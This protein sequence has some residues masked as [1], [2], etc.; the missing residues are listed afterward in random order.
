[1]RKIL[2]F[3]MMA[4]FSVSMF[5]AEPVTVKSTFTKATKPENNKVTDLAE[6]VTWDIATTV[7]AGEP[8][9]AV[10]SSNKVECLK[11]GNSKSIYFSKVEF[12]TDY[13]KDYNVTSVKFGVVNNGNKTGTFTAKQGETTIG[14]E[15]KEFGNSAWEELTATGAKGEGGTLTVTYEVEQAFY[16]SYIEVT[17]EAAGG[18]DPAPT[19]RTLYCKVAQSW[20]KA[21]GAA[22][23]IYAFK[24]EEKNATWPGVRMTLAENET[25][26]WTATID[27]K[28][29]KVIFVRVNASGDIAD[30]GAKTTDLTLADAGE[31]DLYTVTSSEPVWSNQGGVVTGTWSKY[32][33]SESPAQPKYFLKNNWDGADTWTWKEMTYYE[34]EYGAYYYLTQVVFGGTGVNFNTTDSEAGSKWIEAKDIETYD[35]SLEPATL[36]ALDTVVIYFTPEAVNQYTGANGLSAT[37]LGKYVDPTPQP[38]LADGFYLIGKIG[39]VAGWAITDLKA[40]Q[41][42]APNL[43]NPVEFMI[44]VTL[45]EGDELKVVNV[46]NNEITA[47]FPGDDNFIVTAAYAGEKTVYFRPDQQGGEGWHRGCIYIA[48]NPATGISNNAVEGKAVKMIMDGQLLIIRNGK[49]YNVQGQQ[50]K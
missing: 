36:G 40:E 8:A 39:G 44:N 13:Y 16:L 2:S 31:N 18:E 48:P 14:S 41:K 5:A 35:L 22:V 3:L 26:V 6:V 12:S 45:A 17:Y 10:G 4:L 30:W 21:D 11:F 27:A 24:G 47:W 32:T 20:W 15:S 7:G 50:L 37:I 25:D 29:E 43:D 9:I 42:F 19:T 23:G 33:P 38:E 34:D 49:T 46:L 1:M 28:Y